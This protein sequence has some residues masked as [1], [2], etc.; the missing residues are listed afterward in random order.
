MPTYRYEML[1]DD[2]SVVGEF[3]IFQSMNEAPLQRDPVSGRP[4]RR[5][6]SAPYLAFKHTSRHEK[7][8]LSRENLE[9]HGFMRY[10]RAGDGTYVKTAGKGGPDVLSP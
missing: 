1:G 4:C 10:E 3:E 7:K 9:R 2:G 8:S 6:I 5:V